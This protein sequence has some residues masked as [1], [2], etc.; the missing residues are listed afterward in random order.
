[1]SIWQGVGDILSFGQVSRNQAKDEAAARDQATAGW[2][3]LLG[4]QPGME[5]LTGMSMYAGNAPQDYIDQWLA[6]NGYDQFTSDYTAPERRG[7]PSLGRVEGG[8]VGA[9]RGERGDAAIEQAR[10]A[11]L[12]EQLANDP[13]FGLQVADES[14]MAG[15]APD[16][17]YVEAQNRALDQLQGI[18]D[19]GGY[20]DT[21][22]AQMGMMEREAANFERQQRE[23]ALQQAQMRGVGNS[24]ASLASALTAQQGGANRANDWA[25]QIAVAGQNR[26]LDALQGYGQMAGQA[27]Q[28]S[29][30]EDTARRG[31]MDAWNQYRSG[32]IGQRQQQQ[33]AAAQNQFANAMNVT[34]GT[35]GQYNTNANAYQQDQEQ[36][37][38][39]VNTVISAATS[40]A[41]GV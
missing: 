26:A 35:T 34:A 38:E 10:N 19:A 5:D 2:E 13:L 25:N 39:A 30:G 17:R 12:Q 24:G 21:E 41:G 29:F 4:Q 3:E 20:T 27:R 36:T 18:Y 6:E 14:Q 8:V 28:Q 22:R 15:V 16:Q 32:L 40:A 33:G 9:M 37:D 11:W 7:G 1:M 31:A 23:A